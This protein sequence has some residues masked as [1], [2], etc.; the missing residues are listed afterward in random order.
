MYP[1]NS[2]NKLDKSQE[3]EYLDYSQVHL[4]TLR[5]TGKGRWWKSKFGRR[6]LFRTAGVSLAVIIGD[7]LKPIDLA[8]SVAGN[9]ASDKFNTLVLG[10]SRGTEREQVLQTAPRYLWVDVNSARLRSLTDPEKYFKTVLEPPLTGWK[11]LNLSPNQLLGSMLTTAHLIATSFEGAMKGNAIDVLRTLYEISSDC[12]VGVFEEYLFRRSFYECLAQATGEKEDI[13]RCKVAISRLDHEVMSPSVY[14]AHSPYEAGGI[15]G[16]LARKLDN[17]NENE[18]DKNMREVQEE[19]LGRLSKKIQVG[20]E[21][22]LGKKPAMG[23]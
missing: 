8:K 13:K 20:V 2:T 18:R 15:V 16:S 14:Y 4:D 17:K 7:V 22:K 1:K 9:F 19:L 11:Q 10:R 3:E 21:D 5:E 6:A 23:D 12:R